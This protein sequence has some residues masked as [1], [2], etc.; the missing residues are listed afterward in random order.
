MY[1][2]NTEIYT[3][4]KLIIGLWNPWEK[5]ENTRHNIGFLWL[6]YLQDAWSAGEFKAHSKFK[7]EL[8]TCHRRDHQILLLK[9]LTFMNLSWE[10]VQKVMKYYDIDIRDII[11]LSD[12][13][14]IDFWDIRYRVKWGHGGHNGH[15]S[16][17]QSLGDKQIYQR[18]RIGVGRHSHMDVSDWVLSKFNKEEQDE[19]WALFSDVEMFIDQHLFTPSEIHV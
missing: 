4:M 15:R 1:G 18:I 12:D 14:D 17:I 19:F 6:D 7:W 8:A 3:Y 5:Y 9:P 11:V 2:F 13:I 16:I 10:S